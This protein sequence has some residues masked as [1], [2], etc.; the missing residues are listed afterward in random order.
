M[1]MNPTT[2]ASMVSLTPISIFSHRASYRVLGTQEAFYA[3]E[4]E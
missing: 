4:T 1:I 2:K 3:F